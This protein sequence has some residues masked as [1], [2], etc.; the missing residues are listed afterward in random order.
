M[1][2]SFYLFSNFQNSYILAAS[3]VDQTGIFLLFSF[4]SM[5]VNLWMF[6]FFMFSCHCILVYV[7]IV[8]SL[9]NENP[10]SCLLL[11]FNL[12]AVVSLTFLLSHLTRC[13]IFSLCTV[14]CAKPGISHFSKEKLHICVSIDFI[15]VGKDT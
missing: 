11:P 13:L 15:L 9:A 4:L 7:L 8:S 3:K 10:F 6:I 14:F 12:L 1:L 5:T 2:D